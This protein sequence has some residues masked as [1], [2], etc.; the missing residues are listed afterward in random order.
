MRTDEG[1]GIREAGAISRRELLRRSGAA[2]GLLLPGMAQAQEG[3]AEPRVVVVTAREAM[4]TGSTPLAVI[5]K[6]VEKGVTTL[7]GRSDPMQAWASL[8]PKSA[9]VCLATGGGQLE[10]V[11]EVSIAVFRALAAL[12]VN[13]MAV[14]THRMSGAWREKVTAALAERTP[15]L[16]TGKLYGIAHLPMGALV[17]MPTV[18]H[19][20]IA[21][22]SG[23]LKHYA[24]F[25]RTGPWNYHG[26][27]PVHVTSYDG[28]VGGGMGSCGWV[29]ANDFAKP[30]KLHVVDMIRVGTTS[31]GWTCYPEGW[32]YTSA[33]VFSTDPVAA[34]RVAFDLYLKVG[35]GAG[36]IDPFHHVERA[37]TEYRAGVSD[38][39]RIDVRRVS[40]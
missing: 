16:I 30:R 13:S 39:K 6:M 14:G 9:D 19:H 37:E 3:S 20:E 5:E 31:R 28:A 4:R 26:D 17:T 38:L 7:T 10:N 25:S 29:P 11:P 24:T 12:G 18:K 33:L 32:V 21:G 27:T 40:V 22:I 15:Q 35:K 36:R 2:A 1:P 34:D 8:V 23:T